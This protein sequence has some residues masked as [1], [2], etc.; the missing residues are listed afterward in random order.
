MFSEIFDGFNQGYSL[1]QGPQ[2]SDAPRIM[3]SLGSFEFSIDTVAY[4]TLVRDASWRWQEQQRIGKQDLLQYTGKSGRTVKL[5]GEAYQAFRNGISA[6]DD[7]Y[8]LADEAKPQQL[9]TSEGDVLGYWVVKAFNDSINQFIPGGGP[10]HKTFS[11]TIQHYGD[12]L[13][14]P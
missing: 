11:V 2:P 1:A 6:I 12:N 10:R 14:N 4:Q 5:D 9:V 3:L 8:L 13:D 7:L